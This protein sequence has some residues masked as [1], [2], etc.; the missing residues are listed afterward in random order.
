MIQFG[1]NYIGKCK[2][3]SIKESIDINDFS[4][5]TILESNK[6][7]VGKNLTILMVI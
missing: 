1:K 4:I 2:I 6:Y 3:H 5:D 7:H